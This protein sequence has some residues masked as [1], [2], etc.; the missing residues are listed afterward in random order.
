MLAAG[1]AVVVAAAGVGALAAEVAGRVDGAG[2][3]EADAAGV[4]QG[5]DL[6]GAELVG[7]GDVSCDDGSA[8]VHK[9]LQ[10]NRNTYHHHQH[11]IN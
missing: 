10:Q 7:A 8:C 4:D 5:C 11:S 9:Q 6:D 3:A 1:A 2:V